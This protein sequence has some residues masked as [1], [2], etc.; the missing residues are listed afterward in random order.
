MTLLKKM[1]QSTDFNIR[2]STLAETWTSKTSD[3]TDE[4]FKESMLH[5]IDNIKLYHPRYLILD[6]KRS[7]Y[8]VSITSQAWLIQNLGPRLETLEIEKIAVIR[9]HRFLPKVSTEQWVDDLIYHPDLQ[10]ETLCF[11]TQSVAQVWLYH[12]IIKE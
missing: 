12:D 10:I 4:A 5:V 11:D 9:P 3:M 6:F 1:Y 8:T 2:K 7:N